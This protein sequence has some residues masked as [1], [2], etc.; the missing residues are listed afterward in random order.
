MEAGTRPGQSSVWGAYARRRRGLINIGIPANDAEVILSI[1]ARLCAQEQSAAEKEKELRDA[2]LRSKLEDVANQKVVAEVELKSATGAI[3][4]RVEQARA[5]ESKTI[6]QW[7]ASVLADLLAMDLGACVK[8]MLVTYLLVLLEMLPLL[9]KLIAG[10]STV[11]LRISADRT[12]DVI[13]QEERIALAKRDAAISREIGNSMQDAILIACKNPEI[14]R[15]CAQLFAKK[16]AG[17]L[18]LEIVDAFLRE[19]E[20]K[21]FDLDKA[22]RRFPRHAP[23]IV[24]VW[25]DMVREACHILKS[26]GHCSPDLSSGPDDDH[27]KAA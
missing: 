3:S 14:R 2:A 1:A 13:A 9:T 19:L 10:K 20:K 22:L 7:S 4:A 16:V 23:V 24:E 21:Q 11:G 25:S 5:I 17:F 12:I 8:W 15:F 27:Q 6:N 26:Q 18:P